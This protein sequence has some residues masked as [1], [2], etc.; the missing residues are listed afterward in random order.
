VVAAV[1]AHLRA[2]LDEGARLLGG[3]GGAE[4]DL[5]HERV[6]GWLPRGLEA[7]RPGGR[8]RRRI[9]GPG[10]CLLGL[11]ESED[12]PKGLSRGEGLEEGRVGRVVQVPDDEEAA[13]RARLGGDDLGGRRALAPAELVRPRFCGAFL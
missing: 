1:A 7:L 2:P 11:G 5:I 3:E 12:E 10:A 4:P 8:G 9:A 13:V 6:D